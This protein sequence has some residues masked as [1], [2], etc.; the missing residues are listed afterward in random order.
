MCVCVC[1][2]N[3]CVCVCVHTMCACVYIPLFFSL[4]KIVSC[5][6]HCIIIFLF[7]SEIILSDFFFAIK[8]STEYVDVVFVD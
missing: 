2:R 5:V 6:T 8:W 3:V 4:K 7:T 1:A